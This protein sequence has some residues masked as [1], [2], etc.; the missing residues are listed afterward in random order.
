MRLDE[1]LRA[2]PQRDHQ[3]R[4]KELR[5]CQARRREVSQEDNLGVAAA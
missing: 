3:N 4:E 1:V 5:K 2:V